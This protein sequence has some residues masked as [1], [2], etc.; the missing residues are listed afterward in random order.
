MI[1]KK[2]ITL[3]A[4]AI[5]MVGCSKSKVEPVKPNLPNTPTTPIVFKLGQSYQGGK[6]FYIDNSGQH[7]L[8][9][10][11]QDMQG[12][13]DNLFRWGQY[14]LLNT[15][16]DNGQGNTIKMSSKAPSDDYSGFRFKNGY[17]YEGYSDWYIP[18]W[19]EL[20]LLKENK[21]YVGGFATGNKWTKYWSSSEQ[22]EKYALALDFTAM[23]GNP[24]DKSNYSFRIRIIRKF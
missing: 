3:M 18:A 22:S 23:N 19:N 16:Y 15:D 11:T 20:N 10:A 24:Y 12:G 21:D 13:S 1:M 17:Y 4:A 9:A 7:G 14:D 2:I 5:M 8:I 6:I